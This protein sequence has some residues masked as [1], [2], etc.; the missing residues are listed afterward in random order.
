[1]LWFYSI[2]IISGKVW[3]P[4]MVCLQVM[5]GPLREVSFFSYVS[6]HTDTPHNYV[7]RLSPF[8]I[9]AIGRDAKGTANFNEY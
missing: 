4:W 5:R 9:F 2:R 1:M 8:R 3:V 6:H 7:R